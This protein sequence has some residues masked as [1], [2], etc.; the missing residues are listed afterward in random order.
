MPPAAMLDHAG[1]YL[2]LGCLLLDLNGL[3]VQGQRQQKGK[4]LWALFVLTVI[5]RSRNPLHIMAT[6]SLV[7]LE[8]H[9]LYCVCNWSFLFFTHLFILKFAPAAVKTLRQNRIHSQ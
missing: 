7:I 6:I 5:A 8:L 2:L 9:G 4:V 3:E 1:L